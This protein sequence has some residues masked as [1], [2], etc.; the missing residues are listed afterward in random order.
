MNIRK[1][2]AFT[3]VEIVI[4]ISVMATIAGFALVNYRKTVERSYLHDAINQ[5]RTINAANRI[6]H[7]IAGKYW[8][9]DAGTYNIAA[10]NQN[11]SLGIIANGMTYSCTGAT[12]TSFS[13]TAIRNAPAPSFTVTVTDA[14]VS[15]TNP[16]CTAGACP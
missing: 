3:L 15:A 11:L 8:P 14:E 12:G 6:Y 2:Q 10:I 9:P 16:Q 13:C 1:K 4:T 7:S 5:L